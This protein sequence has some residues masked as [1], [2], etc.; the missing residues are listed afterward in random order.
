MS[1]ATTPL[2]RQPARGAAHARPPGAGAA[3]TGRA[4]LYLRVSTPSQVKTDYDPEGLSIPAQR[5]ACERKAEQLG[6]SVVDEYVEPGR[7]ARSMDKRPAFQAML[8]RIKSQRD[9]DFVVVYK[10]SRMNRN[11]IDDA[12]V[13]MALRK[14]NVGL[15]SATENIDDSPV[16]QLIH[17]ILATINEF[18][19]AEDGADI[20]YKMGEKARRGGTLGRAPLGYLNVREQFDG[21]EVRTVAVDPERGAL[22]TTAFGLYATGRY[23]VEQLREELTRRGLRTR[24]GKHPAGPVSV[25]NLCSMLRDRYYLGYVCFDGEEYEGRHEALVSQEVFDRVQ[26]VL[27]AKAASGERQRVHHHYLKGSLWCG[28]CHDAGREFR[29][30]VNRAVGRNKREYFYFFCRGRQERV[31]DLPYLDMDAV[32]EAVARHYA[33]LRLTPEFAARVRAKVREAVADEQQATRLRRTQL[34]KELARLD[35]AEENLLDLV[36]DGEVVSDLARERL[37]K[38]REERQGLTA[39]L[40]R[41]DSQL[42]EGADAIELALCLLADPE[43]LYRR[44]DDQQRRQM[45]QAFFHR[46]YVDTEGVTGARLAAPVAT[47]VEAQAAVGSDQEPGNDKA[48]LLATAL[49]GGVWSKAAMVELRGF[50]P[51]TSCMPCKRSTN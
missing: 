25:S 45:N 10:L 3:A 23:T 1:T 20:R 49:K 22:V 11:R 8:A 33:S 47:L 7:T 39:D 37:R 15:V 31:C 32:D 30:V 6:L 14:Q 35:R 34:T 27:D 21:R 12:L 16:G 38:L 24:A 36:A 26:A 41:I 5:E 48:A 43:R 28:A 42:S 18:R 44:M 4:V 40:E 29:M 51:L 17:G 9:V 2:P 50:E 46:L 19:S 13:M